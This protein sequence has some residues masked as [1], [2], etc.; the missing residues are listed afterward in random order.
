MKNIANV[1]FK[2]SNISSVV[3][4]ARHLDQTLQYIVTLY[5]GLTMIIFNMCGWNAFM[6]LLIA[7]LLLRWLR[8]TIGCS[9][10]V[11]DVNCSF[12][13]VVSVVTHWPAWHKR[14]QPCG[15]IPFKYMYHIQSITNPLQ[16]WVYYVQNH[17]FIYTHRLMH[18]QTHR[19]THAPNIGLQKKTS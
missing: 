19:H 6:R 12:S 14:M 16:L 15:L 4:W 2:Q 18:T 9:V 5:H 8:F 1:R 10:H 3:E 13:N 7:S 11:G 17:A